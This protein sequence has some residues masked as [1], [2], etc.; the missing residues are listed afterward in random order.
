M[1]Y[2]YWVGITQGNAPV[3]QKVA[4][5]MIMDCRKSVK[6]QLHTRP[7]T[8]LLQKKTLRIRKGNG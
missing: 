2:S 1:W 8:I 4:F 3:T 6:N 5:P 7:A